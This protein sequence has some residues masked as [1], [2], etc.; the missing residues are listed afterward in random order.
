MSLKIAS[1]WL[2]TAD[3]PCGAEIPGIEQFADEPFSCV[4]CRR[5]LVL[6]HECYDG[7]ECL[8]Y[9]IDARDYKAHR[10]FERAGL[11][12]SPAQTSR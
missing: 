5:E 9:T 11:T 10:G 8:D 7:S 6:I 4:A 3:C 2:L 12:P 1:A